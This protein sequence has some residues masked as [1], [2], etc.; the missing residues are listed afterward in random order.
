M[1]ISY[2][3]AT[4]MAA[5]MDAQRQQTQA[6]PVPAPI[7]MPKTEADIVLPAPAQPVRVRSPIYPAI[8]PPTNWVV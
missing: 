5:Q 4:W 1:R 2:A 8:T 6:L 7:S 3:M